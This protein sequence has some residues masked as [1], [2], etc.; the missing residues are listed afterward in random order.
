MTKETSPLGGKID[1]ASAL[2]VALKLLNKDHVIARWKYRDL[3]RNPGSITDNTFHVWRDHLRIYTGYWTEIDEKCHLSKHD[4]QAFVAFAENEDKQKRD[5]F[6]RMKYGKYLTKYHPEIENEEVKRLVAE[7]EYKYGAPPELKIGET[8][9][10]FV[11]AI[12][13]GPGDSCQAD[14]FYSGDRFNFAGHEHPA[15]CYASGDIAV[16]WIEDSVGRVTARALINK[17]RKRHSRPYGDVERIDR[18]L[19]DAGYEKRSGALIGCRLEVIENQNGC[20][21]LMPYVDAGT[22]SGGGSLYAEQNDGY[23]W[24]NDNGDGVSTA[25]GYEDRGITTTDEGEEQEPEYG[26]CGHCGEGIHDQDDYVCSEYHS[27]TYCTN[28]ADRRWQYAIVSVG[29]GRNNFNYDYVNQNDCTF[30]D[31]LNEHALDEIIDELVVVK[32]ENRDEWIRYD[33]A[34]QRVYDE[35]YHHVDDCVAAGENSNGA[36]WLH[37]ED[38]KDKNLAGKIYYDKDNKP[39]WYESDEIREWVE[40]GADL[41]R[42]VLKAAVDAGQ[43]AL[44][45]SGRKVEIKIEPAATTGSCSATTEPVTGSCSATTEPVTGTCPNGT[46]QEI[47]RWMQAQGV[48]FEFSS[49]GIN[50]WAPECEHLNFDAMAEPS[51]YRVKPGQPD[52]PNWREIFPKA[53]EAG[54]KF[55][56]KSDVSDRWS[57][58]HMR[59]N[60]DEMAGYRIQEATGVATQEERIAA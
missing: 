57:Y 34:V 46:W 30:I 31:C 38:L 44:H 52:V 58:R 43:G 42:Y 33:D 20:G 56:V 27:S 54:I 49:N 45:L 23:W 7:F 1:S 22:S 32:D 21:W 10:D 13:D 60:G 50:W 4:G 55:E 18:L 29:R 8:A 19:A 41:D 14:R 48:K 16:A 37:K 47:Y 59:F 51:H 9:E 36:I 3:R 26:H 17:E 12:K 2:R 15:V 11:H 35:E 53:Q 28:C 40:D 39:F 5:V 24:L 6:T 25:C